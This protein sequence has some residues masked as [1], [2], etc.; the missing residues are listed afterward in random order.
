MNQLLQLCTART[1]FSILGTVQLY[2]EMPEEVCRWLTDG[3]Q[4]KIAFRLTDQ[5]L[6]ISS[7]R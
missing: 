2:S 1:V 5:L 3:K 6:D 7:N 4:R